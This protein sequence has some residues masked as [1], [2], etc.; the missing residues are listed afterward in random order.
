MISND[1]MNNTYSQWATYTLS[2]ISTSCRISET[3]CFYYNLN[4]TRMYEKYQFK[5]S[6]Y[7]TAVN[8]RFL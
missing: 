3:T 8:F 5:A 4:I 6:K 1:H 7:T 2:D